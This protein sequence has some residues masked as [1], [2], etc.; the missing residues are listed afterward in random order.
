M[1]EDERPKTAPPEDISLK[2]LIPEVNHF[3]KLNETR[4][5]IFIGMPSNEEQLQAFRAFNIPIDKYILLSDN[6]EENPNKNLSQR[7][8]DAELEQVAAFTTAIAPVKDALT[9][10]IFKEVL[11]GDTIDNLTIKVR[12]IIDP[13]FLKPD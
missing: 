10:E 9:E 13:F 4:G 7:L 5:F 8:N 2:D 12:N 11:I 1:K 6:S 3:G